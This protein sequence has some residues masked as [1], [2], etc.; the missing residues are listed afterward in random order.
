M[1]LHAETW[2]DL[3]R[4]AVFPFFADPANLQALTPPWLHF[5][6]ATPQPVAMK[7]GTTIAYRLRIR[8]VP[9]TWR[10]EISAYEPPEMFVD[11]Q[12]RG[13]YRRWVHTH[14][15]IPDRGGTLLVDDVEFD[16]LLPFL[17]APL[18]KRDLQTIF[19]FRHRAL[20]ARFRQP[21][22]WPAPNILFA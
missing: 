7:A 2:V 16:M 5:Q 19:T 20:L 14:R 8:G 22:P 4:A 12:L 17:V 10:S 9:V 3:P 11:R 13:P 6:I 1:R 21:E 15:F 18:V